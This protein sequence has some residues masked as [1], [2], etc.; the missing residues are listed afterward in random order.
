MARGRRK[1]KVQSEVVIPSIFDEPT[2][3]DIKLDPVQETKQEEPVSVPASETV[4]AE[5]VDVKLPET[6]VV[7][8]AEEFLEPPVSEP[9]KVNESVSV[10]AEEPVPEP[11]KMI[12]AEEA[13]EISIEDVERVN[14]IKI[15]A[16]PVKKSAPISASKARMISAKFRAIRNGKNVKFAN[17]SGINA[18]FTL[19]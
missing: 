5:A 14:N 8:V 9:V 1:K 18:R 10:P 13:P 4:I 11:L 2:I 7:D 19:H 17:K 12:V 3:N 15:S 6:E 16:T